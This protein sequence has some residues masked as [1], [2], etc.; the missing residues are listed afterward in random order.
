MKPP[1][2]GN[3]ARQRLLVGAALLLV[4]GALSWWPDAGRESA[5]AVQACGPSDTYRASLTTE[6]GRTFRPCLSKV[7]LRIQVPHR[8]YTCGIF[9]TCYEERWRIEGISRSSG[10]QRVVFAD[11]TFED[12]YRLTFRSFTVANNLTMSTGQVPGGPVP[13]YGLTLKP[14]SSAKLGGIGSAGAVVYTDMWVTGDSL[15]RFNFNI[16]GIGYTCAS[17][18][19]VDELGIASWLTVSVSGCGMDLHARYVVTTAETGDLA[20]QYSVKLP[21][22]RVTVS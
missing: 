7:D 14:D 10:R 1:G 6:N 18:N 3:R 11:G 12:L 2:S 5:H 13:G 19:R 22:T 17:D 9:F 16:L 21:A 4:L 15:V 8:S 20:G